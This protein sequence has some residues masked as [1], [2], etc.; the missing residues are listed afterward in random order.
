MALQIL[1]LNLAVVML[2]AA[3][4]E[5]FAAYAMRSQPTVP[6]VSEGYRVRD[7][8]LGSS[9]PRG[10]I[11]HARLVARDGVVVYDVQYS[12]GVDGLRVSP[13]SVETPRGWV[14]ESTPAEDRLY[15]EMIRAL[16]DAGIVVHEVSA[17][18]PGYAQDPRPFGL[19]WPYDD[20]PSA[21]TNDLLARYVVEH[22]LEGPAETRAGLPT[23]PTP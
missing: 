10:A 22:I 5:A 9:P 8:V 11:G 13:P 15:Q 17:I 21:K 23:P 2:L 19:M 6:V 3:G 12:T 4:C 18:L 1:W 20:H 7:D 14:G 16:K